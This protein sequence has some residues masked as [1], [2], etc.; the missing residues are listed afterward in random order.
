MP[1]ETCPI[2]CRM[3]GRLSQHLLT[4]HN[5]HN[6]EE[7][8]LLLAI[9]SGRINARAGNCPIPEC[10]KS[11]NRLD[12]H[13]RTHSEISVVEQEDAILRCK[14]RV[15]INKLTALRASNP[16]IP[17]VSTL[18]LEECQ[19]TE[20]ADVPPDR[21]DQEEEECGN[22]GCKK[23]KEFLRSQVADLNKLVDILTDSLRNVTR[24]FRTLS[25]RST[26]SGAVRVGQVVRK[27]L[28][29]F[30]NEEEA[31]Q[32]PEQASGPCEPSTSEQPTETPCEE[33]SVSADKP[34]TAREKSPPQYPDH[35]T[36]LNELMEGYSRYLLGPDPTRKLREN[37]GGQ[38]YRIKNFIA[39]MSEGK[40]KLSDFC[41]LNDTAKIHRPVL[42]VA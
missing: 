35:V 1:V 16:E 15:V 6:K 4:T 12:R 7:R 13:I 17:M 34:S 25:R 9:E 11:S 23:Q 42:D 20:E 8:K 39:Y 28:S 18:D 36:V 19:Q 3:Y 24:R 30:D 14:R 5:V 21:E 31:A 22:M 32:P 40:G 29:T 10:G 27:L 26:P 38:I 41:F 37:V 2:C 33:P